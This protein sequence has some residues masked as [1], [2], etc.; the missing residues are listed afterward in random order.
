M[1]K[2]IGSVV[3]LLVLSIYV[4]VHA[5]RRKS[6]VA[7]SQFTMTSSAFVPNG[8]IPI[9]YTCDGENISPDLQWSSIPK[10]TQSF[11]LIVDDPDAPSQIW[12]HWV[13]YNIPASVRGLHSGVDTS[14]YTVGYNDFG[15]TT[16][17]GPCPPSGTHHYR[18]TL[19]ALDTM[20][21]VVRSR[22]TKQNLLTWMKGHILAQSTL[23]GTYAR[24]GL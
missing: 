20:L 10:G 15:N 22:V 5:V 17:G 21:P 16:Y 9:K 18:F 1:Q 12:V 23:V 7:E 11:A 13:L 19:Y 6:V 3:L 8:V 2:V 24:V 14:E 4:C